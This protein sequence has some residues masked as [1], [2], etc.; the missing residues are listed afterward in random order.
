MATLLGDLPSTSASTTDQAVV[1][2]D[3]YRRL[4]RLATTRD[5]ELCI[6]PIGSPSEAVPIPA[7]AM[8]LLTDILMQMA[9]G[10]T[11]TVVPVDTELTTQQAADLLHVSRPFL[12]ERMEGGEIPFKKVGT[13][14]RVLFEDVMSYKSRID[15][16]RLKVL[17]ELTQ[18]A[19]E[20]GM[21]Y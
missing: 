7:P 11:V 2:Q 9:R 19:Q 18:Q 16:E 21:G 5:S 12:I 20:L 3:C 17:D 13:H 10:K 6:Q 1:A 15:Q 4:A 14:R 8:Q